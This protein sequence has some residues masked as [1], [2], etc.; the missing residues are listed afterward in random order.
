MPL[1]KKSDCR[2]FDDRVRESR[3][4]CH[5]DLSPDAPDT[6]RQDAIAA[7]MAKLSAEQWD[8]VKTQ[9]EAGASDRAAATEAA[10]AVSNQQLKQLELQNSLTEGYA[11]DRENLYRPLE[12]QIV[13]EASEFDTPE[14]RAAAAN[15]AVAD[16]GIQAELA[17]QAQVRNQQ[18]MGVNPSSGKAL[19]LDSALRLGEATAKAGAA[20]SARDQ[21]ETQGYARKLDAANLG[22][23]AASAQATSAS[24]ASQTGS[25]AV[26]AA[27]APNTV[28]NQ[29]IGVV[30][31]GANGALSGL[32]GAAGIYGQSTQTQANASDNSGLYSALGNLGGAAL[33]KYSDK[34]MKKGRAKVARELSLA[35]IRKL[36]D[37]ETYRYRDDSPAADG[38]QV[39]TG[40]MAQDVQAA[41]GDEVAPGGRIV[42]LGGMQAHTINAVKALD[43]RVLALEHARKG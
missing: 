40:H 36:P 22:R 43:D 2:R 5:L 19:A 42:D 33:F 35:A 1:R 7:D 26:N 31:S 38:G 23:G 37:A 32:S 30:Q 15:S 11:A 6:S 21:V 34:N 25:S 8:W 20:N 12:Q 18:R 29:G 3:S 28:N 14:R 13:T 24:I 41:M 39:H 9:Y 27:Q 10:R 17:R 4:I 16:V